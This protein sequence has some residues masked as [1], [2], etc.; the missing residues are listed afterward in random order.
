MGVWKLLLAQYE[1]CRPRVL[2]GLLLLLMAA[3]FCVFLAASNLFLPI[4]GSSVMD[5]DMNN[6]R[7]SLMVIAAV[8]D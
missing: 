3:M 2:L 7:T 1:E 8:W 4:D 6:N 5:L